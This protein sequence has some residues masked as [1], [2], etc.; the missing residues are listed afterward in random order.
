MSEHLPARCW[1]VADY[2]VAAAMELFHDQEVSPILT[3]KNCTNHCTYSLLTSQSNIYCQNLQGSHQNTA[4]GID[5]ILPFSPDLLSTIGLSSSSRRASQ[6]ASQCENNNP[7]RWVSILLSQPGWRWAACTFHVLQ[8]YF[9]HDF[10][11]HHFRFNGE[12]MSFLS[13]GC[14]LNPQIDYMKEKGKFSRKRVLSLLTIG[15][16]PHHKLHDYLSPYAGATA[17]PIYWGIFERV[18][19]TRNCMFFMLHVFKH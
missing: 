18:D 13:E 15:E 17:L 14:Q 9:P 11:H 3:L 4:A 6:S 5:A 19:P 10:S 7:P 8:S 1:N 16:C 12:W 2:S